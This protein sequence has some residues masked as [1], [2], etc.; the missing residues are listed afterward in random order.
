MAKHSKIFSIG[1]ALLAVVAAILL[2]TAFTTQRPETASALDALPQPNSSA[3]D[4]MTLHATIDRTVE[5]ARPAKSTKTKAPAPIATDIASDD[6]SPAP[7][8]AAND[9]TL[10]TPSGK[11]L[12]L[13]PNLT[14]YFDDDFDESASDGKA[15]PREPRITV[16]FLDAMAI[17]PSGL[18]ALPEKPQEPADNVSTPEKIE[19]GRLLYFDQRLSGDN[20]M[21]CATCHHPDSG[22]ADGQSLATGFGQMELGR[23]SPTVLNAAYNSKQFWDGRADTLEQQAAGPIMAE[24]EMNIG[25]EEELI[26]RLTADADYPGMF[27]S[28]FGETPTLDNVAKAIA[29]FERTIVTPNSPFDAYANGDKDALNDSEKRGLI[30]FFGKASCT[31]CHNGPNFTDDEYYNLGL[32]ADRSPGADA[33][34]ASV[35]DTD[36]DFGAF[37]TPTVRNAELTAPFMHDGSVHTLQELVDFYDMGGRDGVNKSDLIRPLGLTPKEKADLVAFMKSLT[38]TPPEIKDPWQQSQPTMTAVADTIE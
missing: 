13:A 15:K 17:L 3:L 25:S 23:H 14:M 19:L 38:G 20:S 30:L 35:N 24:V 5:E 7:E 6:T 1:G 36:L 9:G 18:A 34:R 16:A 22:Y 31:N 11:T 33:G 37:R 26:S 21:S 12:I 10:K 29:A 2:T 27:E 32:I 28:V 8:T 4:Q